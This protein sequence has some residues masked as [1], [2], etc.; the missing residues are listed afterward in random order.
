VTKDIAADLDADE[1][2]GEGIRDEPTE[3]KAM[4]GRFTLATPAKSLKE[5]FKLDAIPELPLRYNISPTQNV[6]AIRDT[7]KGRTLSLLRWGL[8]PHWESNT[9]SGCE[10]AGT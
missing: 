6:A 4:C 5:H 10:E 2:M 7:A 3:R 8:I 1:R 9:G